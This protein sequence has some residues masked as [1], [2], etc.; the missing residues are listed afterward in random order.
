MPFYE[1]HKDGMTIDTFKYLMTLPKE[2]RTFVGYGKLEYNKDCEI[3][4]G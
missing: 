3:K 4:I 2:M 1:P